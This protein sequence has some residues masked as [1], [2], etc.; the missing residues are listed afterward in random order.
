M[1]TRDLALK[2]IEEIIDG[3]VGWDRPKLSAESILMAIEPYI[4]SRCD[5]A[6]SDMEFDI[7][8]NTPQ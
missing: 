4:Q 1:V 7:N 2:S 3:F 6:A 8:M 5:E